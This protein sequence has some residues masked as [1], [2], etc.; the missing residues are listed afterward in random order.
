MGDFSLSANFSEKEHLHIAF[1][2]LLLGVGLAFTGF[3]ILT[4]NSS[5]LMELLGQ[6]GAA[7]FVRAL[8]A[9]VVILALLSIPLYRLVR[10][11]AG[12]GR[13]RSLGLLLVFDAALFVAATLLVLRSDNLWAVSG[14][15]ICAGGGL[16]ILICLWGYIY[17]GLLPE[18]AL[19]HAALAL[20]LSTLLY[21]LSSLTLLRTVPLPLVLGL[22][23]LAAISAVAAIVR[24][25]P[26]VRTGRPP[27]GETDTYGPR[28]KKNDLPPGR[29]Q[30][31]GTSEQDSPRQRKIL[32]SI[33]RTLWKPLLSAALSAFLE[34][35]VWDF[36]AAQVSQT[37][38]AGSDLAII[39]GAPLFVA[40]VVIAALRFRPRA[41]TLH[42]FCEVVMPIAIAVLLVMPIIPNTSPTALFAIGF[43][44]QMCFAVIV[45]AAW[46]SLANGVRTSEAQA[47][48]LFSFGSALFAACGLI[49][50]WAIGI[51]GTGGQ[52]VCFVL[53]ALFLV[54]MIV[55]FAL[56]DSIASSSR[57]VMRN[58]VERYL[59][60]RCD[61]LAEQ[62]G[63]SAREREV[64]LYLARGYSHVYIAKELY[65]SENTV[66]THVKHIYGKL[67]ISSR[68]ALLQLIDSQN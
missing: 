44:T 30:D 5:P 40:V 46:T 38:L 20:G 66:H 28:R 15:G 25:P 31:A 60:N 8:L 22:A 6:A 51:I 1:N 62:H 68:E 43:L 10:K 9:G 52:T 13:R 35:L 12:G 4:L 58:V 37:R 59:T 63:L 32:G 67:D 14:A 36:M 3:L 50:M 34:G 16:L 48:A 23:L 18:N 29:T 7:S 55:D 42:V 47:W 57:E 56:R 2:P 11:F 64:F 27:S 33:L 24:M 41:F 61:E 26:S 49:G 54:L 21:P 53:F 45:L 39:V 65:V 19:F 17:S